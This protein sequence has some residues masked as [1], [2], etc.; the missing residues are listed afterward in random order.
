M[1]HQDM[2]AILVGIEHYSSDSVPPVTGAVHD[3]DRM[4][5]LLVQEMGVPPDHIMVLKN[6]AATRYGILH[7][8]E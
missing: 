1:N 5:N 8:F 2:W 4:Y 6:E 7:A 3:V